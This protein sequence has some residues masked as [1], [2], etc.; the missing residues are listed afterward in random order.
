MRVVITI[1]SCDAKF[2][3]NFE[4]YMSLCNRLNIVDC[5]EW[6]RME[7][8]Y[9]ILKVISCGDWGVVTG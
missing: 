7:L 9:T 6:V 5:L 3:R 2:Q 4:S 1:A 8:P